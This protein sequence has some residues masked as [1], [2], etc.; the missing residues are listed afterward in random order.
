MMEY[1]H[2]KFAIIS[3]LLPWVVVTIFTTSCSGP[4]RPP[5]EQSSYN[6]PAEQITD[7]PASAQ[8]ISAGQQLRFEHI[9]LEHGLSQSTVFC[10]L[11]DSQGFMWFGTEDGLNKY[12][13]FNFTV[14]RHD[15]EDPGS[16][17]GNW[18]TALFEDD[19]GKLWVGTSDSG[20]SRFDRTRDAFI[21]YRNDPQD[22]NSLSDDTI[23]AIYQD[24]EGVLWIG[25]GSGGLDRFDQGNQR[26]VH[27][28][29]NQDDPNSLSSNAVTAIYGDREGI[30]WIGTDAGVLNKFDRG[31]D[32]WLHYGYDPIDSHNLGHHSITAI[33]EDQSGI[34][35]IGTG[36]GGLDRFDPESEKVT[37]Y[38]HNPGDPE[39]LSNGNIN[40]IY[41]DRDG[42]LWIGTWGGGLNLFVPENETFTHYQHSP[43]DPYS[44]NQDTILSIFQDREGVLW[45][46]TTGAGVN[47]L[48]NAWRNFTLYQNIPEN[49]DSLS[50]NMVRTFYHD[51]DDVLWIG[52]MFG[53]LDRFDRQTG[54]W[55]HFRHDP[56]DPSSLSNNFVSKV[57]RDRF[58]TLW[59]GTTS[60]LDKLIPESGNFTHYQPE[61][62]G[63]PGSPGNNIRTIY[64]VQGG[65]FWIGTKNGFLQFDRQNESWG[66]P[67]YP[68]PSDPNS[69]SAEWIF[70]FLEDRDG[71]LW[72]GTVGGGV[73]QFDPETEKFIHYQNDPDE[74]NSLSTN[75]VVSSIFQ[76]QENVLWLATAGALER[77]DPTTQTFTHYRKK[78]GL[79]NETVYC[80][81]EDRD[82][83]IWVSTNAGLS[84]FDPQAE[85]FKNYEVMDGLQSNEFNSS[86]CLENESGEMFFGGID[87]FNV[88]S[89]DQI[90]SNRTVPQIVLTSLVHD[91]EAVNPGMAINNVT[92]VELKWPHNAFEFEFA[93]LSY[94]RPEKNQY[95]YY[96]EGFEDDWNLVGTRRYGQYT[97][98]PGGTYTLHVKGSNNDGVWNETGTSVKIT[99]VPPI[100]ATW[101]FRAS[102]ALLVVGLAFLSYRLRV[103]NIEN[104]SRDLEIQVEERT[105]EL[106]QE[107]AQ[108]TQIEETLRNSEMEKAVADE[109]SRLARELHDSVT[110]SLYSLTL[111]TEAARHLAEEDGNKSIEQYIGQIGTIGLQALKEMRLLVFE[112]RPPELEKEGLVRALRRRLEAVEGRA[113][114]DARL[115]VDDF[116][117]LPGN[118]EQEF[119]RITQEALN[120]ALKHAAA[121]TVVV[122]LR[123]ENRTIEMEIIDNGVGF[124]PQALPD[125][126]GMGLKN[127]RE[128]AERIGSTVAIHSKPGDGTS[129]KITIEDFGDAQQQGETYE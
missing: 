115:V 79:P 36:G 68:D 46:G 71:K 43:S 42:M 39:S 54:I 95:A 105:N 7:Q 57:Y 122:N 30:I 59:I 114:V 55:R 22:S 74:P 125:R 17:R 123:Q 100:W 61:P 94:T 6:T 96:L 60:G 20:L 116:V 28:Q 92:A 126:G 56:N 113:G 110:Q 16:L 83:Y 127:I 25:T 85:T 70:S 80:I 129:I 108:R 34:L 9:S 40:A 53:G 91:G 90:K 58:G 76:D 14:Y 62:D 87:G 37:H 13:G 26:F 1:N 33:F 18:I 29:N 38:Q 4:A 121:S 11:Q 64:E 35:W 84:R 66:Q 98:L 23:S 21:H 47:K 118:I 111:F 99:I 48:N 101:W 10:V 107:I 2:K 102:A 103:R 69:L 104:R 51:S 73:N 106:Q 97:N 88:F 49:P 27:Y 72:I 75:V 77:F 119:F 45:F 8:K 50:D 41:Q 19:L 120:N 65:E 89:P 86:A 24:W 12:D 78:D 32:R 128:R 31:N 67:Y 15:P 63:P 44:L 112:L 82:R 52:S 109:R 3:A 81:V 5:K 124:D 117:K 93:A